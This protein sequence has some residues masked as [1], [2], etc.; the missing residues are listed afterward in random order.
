MAN[1]PLRPVHFN[2]NQ[3]RRKTAITVRSSFSVEGHIQIKQTLIHRFVPIQVAP[4]S[5]FVSLSVLVV[6][7]NGETHW[8]LCEYS[9]RNN[10]RE[11]L[12]YELINFSTITRKGRP[13]IRG[14]LDCS[15]GGGGVEMGRGPLESVSLLQTKLTTP[16]V[17]YT[18]LPHQ[19][20]YLYFSF[21]YHN[22]SRSL[23]PA[24]FHSENALLISSFNKFRNVQ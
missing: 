2:S 24:L 4:S 19:Q 22:S 8:N 17:I 13:A 18:S 7:I 1:K 15:L 20:F 6:V 23:D 3:N 16:F 5:F 12:P 14:R 9:W 10:C 21:N 11:Q